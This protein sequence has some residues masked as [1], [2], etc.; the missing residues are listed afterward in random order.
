MSAREKRYR[1]WWYQLVIDMVKACGRYDINNQGELT[2]MFYEAIEKAYE[3][4]GEDGEDV[5]RA[6]DMMYINHTHTRTGTAEVL[7]MS[8]CTLS[9]KISRFIYLVGEYVGLKNDTKSH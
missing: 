7:H 4:L 3:T 2:K 5:K 9:R 6:I 1:E 8:E